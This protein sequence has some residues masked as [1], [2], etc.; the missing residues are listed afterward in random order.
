[1]FDKATTAAGKFVRQSPYLVLGLA[2]CVPCIVLVPDRAELLAWY[3][4]KASI[5]YAI[6]ILIDGAAAK[7]ADPTVTTPA[8]VEPP[9]L[10]QQRERN[11]QFALIRRA[12]TV[13]ALQLAFGLAA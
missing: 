7:P 3:I 6:G 12:I 10:T 4:G 9:E 11:R 2:L 5:A 8:D 13:G 1:M